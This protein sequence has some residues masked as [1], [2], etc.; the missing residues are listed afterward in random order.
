MTSKDKPEITGSADYDDAVLDSGWLPC[1]ET[2]SPEPPMHPPRPS[3]V[4]RDDADAFLQGI[5]RSEGSI[6]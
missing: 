5:Y 4:A 6:D 2:V 3:R 1:P